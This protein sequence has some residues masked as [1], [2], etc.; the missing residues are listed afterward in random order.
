MHFL[1]LSKRAAV[2]LT[3]VLP[4]RSLSVLRQFLTQYLNS[5]DYRHGCC[6]LTPFSS[7]SHCVSQD[8]CAGQ[9]VQGFHPFLL[10]FPLLFCLILLLL[11]LLLVFSFLFAVVGVVFSQNPMFI[12]NLGDVK[13]MYWA[14]ITLSFHK[15]L[16]NT[17]GAFETTYSQQSTD[18][19]QSLKIAKAT[20]KK[21]F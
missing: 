10:A 1:Y 15:I 6:H 3:P 9:S 16:F 7:V 14:R 18:S 2:V 12:E 5:I 13:L 20:L 8:Q 4:I 19:Q 21:E 11:L 17:L